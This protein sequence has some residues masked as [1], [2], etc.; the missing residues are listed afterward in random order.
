MTKQTRGEDTRAR[1]LVSAEQGFAQTGYDSTGVAEICKAAGVSKG[2][3]YHHFTSKEEVFLELLDRWLTSL[4]RQLADVAASD[5]SLQEV[6][7]GLSKM[8]PQIL[9]EAGG[10][11]S[12]LLEFWTKARSDPKVWQSTV[13]Y[14]QRYREFFVG[15]LANTPG[16]GSMALEERQAAAGVLVAMIIGL[17]LWG[18]LDPKAADWSCVTR[19]GLEL[20][21]RGWQGKGLPS[22]DRKGEQK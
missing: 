6:L 9:Q 20:F 14:F 2:A 4:D 21:V 5:G 16:G 1:I 3:F 13:A 11:Y 10:Q 15:L 17:L 12:I 19:T 7:D 22:N 8:A 18:A